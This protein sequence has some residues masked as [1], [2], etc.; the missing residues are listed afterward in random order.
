[1]PR[2]LSAGFNILVVIFNNVPVADILH[3]PVR[4]FRL[5]P[6]SMRWWI[7]SRF[8]GQCSISR[9][10]ASSFSYSAG[11]VTSYS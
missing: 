8:S 11:M 5:F 4:A 1:L 10:L 6:W 7:S 3:V 2:G 9:S